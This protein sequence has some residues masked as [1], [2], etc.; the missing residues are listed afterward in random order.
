MFGSEGRESTDIVLGVDGLA[1]VVF[2]FGDDAPV[3]AVARE[4]SADGIE[5]LAVGCG[6]C[7]R[8]NRR[9]IEAGFD[10]GV[11]IDE[12][13]LGGCDAIAELVDVA[14]NEVAGLIEVGVGAASIEGAGAARGVGGGPCD[15][16]VVDVVDAGDAF[17]GGSAIGGVAAASTVV[18]EN[19][20]DEVQAD[21][22]AHARVAAMVV[23]VEIVMEGDSSAAVADE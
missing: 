5:D 9:E 17:V 8:C 11:P 19:V 14:V 7:F 18:V 6:G 12:G 20:V 2:D 16:V 3:D 15:G 1:S 22:V 4:R 21:F 23:D 10:G 13:G